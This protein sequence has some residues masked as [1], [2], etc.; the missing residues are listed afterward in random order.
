MAYFQYNV[1]LTAGQKEKMYKAYQKKAPFTL[2]L[3]KNTTNR[4]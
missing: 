4:L 3:K 2:R 1:S